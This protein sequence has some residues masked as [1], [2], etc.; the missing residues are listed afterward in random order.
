MKKTAA[1]FLYNSYPEVE[2]TMHYTKVVFWKT[3]TI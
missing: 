3:L 1:E 2:S